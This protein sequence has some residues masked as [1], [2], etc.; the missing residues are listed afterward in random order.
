MPRYFSSFT[1]FSVT[2][3]SVSLVRDRTEAPILF[4]EESPIFFKTIFLPTELR[5]M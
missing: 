3:C 1:Q 4:K 2:T 5:R